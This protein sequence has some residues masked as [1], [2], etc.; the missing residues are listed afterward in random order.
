M[1]LNFEKL[2]SYQEWACWKAYTVATSDIFTSAAHGLE[3]NDTIMVYPN[4]GV[5]ATPLTMETCYYVKR[6]DA[7]TFYLALTPGGTNI[8]ITAVGSG[9]QRFYRSRDYRVFTAGTDNIITSAAHKL[10]EGDIIYLATNGTLPEPLVT[11]TPYYVKYIDTDTFKV[12]L[13]SGGAEVDI[14]TTGTNTHWFVFRIGYEYIHIGDLVTNATA[15]ATGII[16]WLYRIQFQMG[17]VY[18]AQIL[19][20][21]GSFSALDECTTNNGGFFVLYGTPTTATEDTIVVD[22]TDDADSTANLTGAISSSVE[23]L[24]VTDYSVLP[25]LRYIRLDSEWI[26]ILAAVNGSVSSTFATASSNRLY[27]VG[28]GLSTGQ[29]IRLTTTGTLPTGLSTGVGYYVKKQD[30]NYF[31]VSLTLGGD[32]VA[33]TH[34]SGSGTH[35]FTLQDDLTVKRGMFGTTA[36]SHADDIDIF[37]LNENIADAI[38]IEDAAQSWGLCDKSSGKYSIG[39]HVMVGRPDQTGKTIALSVLDRVTS[40]NLYVAG[41]KT[42]GTIF[43][44]GV[45]WVDPGVGVYQGLYFN[46][47]N[48]LFDDLFQFRDS[49]MNIYGGSLIAA[50]AASWTQCG[51]CNIM[52][53]S[54]ASLDYGGFPVFSNR[55]ACKV[56]RSWV[57]NQRIS[58]SSMELD[59]SGIYINYK[60]RQESVYF[61][62]SGG[63]STVRNVETVDSTY[64]VGMFAFAAGGTKTFIDCD[65]SLSFGQYLAQITCIH[66]KSLSMNA[67]TP[68]GVAVP[69]VS[70]KVYDKNGVE[71]VNTTT[72]SLGWCSEKLV[73][74]Y[75]TDDDVDLN[76]FKFVITKPGWKSKVFDLQVQ[77][78]KRLEF[79][80]INDERSEDE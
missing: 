45:G 49:L 68:E 58:V 37:I 25:A 41:D 51:A 78:P 21:S 30:N 24:Y 52:T 57:N 5:L 33:V 3:D 1:A 20:V 64:D 40:Q 62:A 6:I 69:N 19:V 9:A 10:V 17:D 66:Q 15:T 27:K 12:S 23:T 74:V 43:Q 50:P 47:C 22:G 60:I 61:L 8:N 7:N 34:P 2:N 36:A 70:I 11:R 53:A 73:T 72:D 48:W 14:T 80:L 39:A 38:C 31:T 42:Y 13:T 18:Q 77:E 54:L 28:H 29:V 75:N 26:F 71:V 76:P 16:T 4:S 56:Y 63:D 32:D 65:V 55:Q 79:T 35:T 44:S 46:G 59:W 67:I